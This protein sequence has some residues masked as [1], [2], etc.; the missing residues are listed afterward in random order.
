MTNIT[1]KLQNNNIFPQQFAWIDHQ[2]TKGIS[3]RI[4]RKLHATSQC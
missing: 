1:G 4:T 2:Q 3:D